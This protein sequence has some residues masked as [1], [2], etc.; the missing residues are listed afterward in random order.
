MSFNKLLKHIVLCS[1]FISLLFSFSFAQH[2]VRMTD[3][4]WIELA[5]DMIRKGIQQEDT[6]KVFMVFA[7]Q[8]LVKGERPR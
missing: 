2:F 6:T 3:Q 1:I 5:L 4:Q 7:P 8:V